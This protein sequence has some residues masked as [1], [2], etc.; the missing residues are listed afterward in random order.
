MKI[1]CDQCNYSTKSVKSILKH[2][3]L[4]KAEHLRAEMTAEDEEAMDDGGEVEYMTEID[5]ATQ[6][7]WIELCSTFWYT[8]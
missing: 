6:Q 7:G 4:H 8:L 1:K 5:D 3:E 2:K